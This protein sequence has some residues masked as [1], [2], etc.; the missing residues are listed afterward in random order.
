MKD[1][2]SRIKLESCSSA[3]GGYVLMEC[4]NINIYILLYPDVPG[5][6]RAALD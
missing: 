1:V 2:N 5:L 3:L 6:Q 4:V